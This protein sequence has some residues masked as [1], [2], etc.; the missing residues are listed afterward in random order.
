MGQSAYL[1]NRKEGICCESHKISCSGKDVMTIINS[2]VL[3]LFLDYCMRNQLTLEVVSE[4]WF[5]NLDVDQY[6]MDIESIEDLINHAKKQIKTL[7][8][9]T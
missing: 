8:Q 1:I 7:N 9:T 3:A 2:D 6:F 5:N 4:N